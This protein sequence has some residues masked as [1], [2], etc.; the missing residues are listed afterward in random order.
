MRW[1]KATLGECAT[2]VNGRAYKQEELL[3]SGTPVLRIQNLNG[4]DKWYYSDLSLPQDKYCE[5]GDLLFAWSS[6]FGPYLWN[7][8][9]AIYHY[10]IW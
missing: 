10:H 3:E 4:G 9:K 5:N 1:P 2:L 8:P 7:G 6:S